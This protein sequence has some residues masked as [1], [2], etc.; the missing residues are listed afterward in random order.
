[1]A[2]T[3]RLAPALPLALVVCAV[4]A[5]LVPGTG[6]SAKSAMSPAPPPPVVLATW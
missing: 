4:V 2:V 1:M 5:V 6:V 3:S